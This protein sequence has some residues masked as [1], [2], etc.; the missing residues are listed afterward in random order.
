MPRTKKKSNRYWTSITEYAVAAYNRVESPVTREK[1]YLR[2]LYPALMKMSENLIN[3]LKPEYIDSSFEDL[4]TDLVTFLTERLAKFNPTAGK[5]YSYYTRTGFNY[6]IA[7]NQKAYS[8]LKNQYEEI[9][10]DEQRNVMIEIHNS[11]MRE[12]LQHFMDAYIQYCYDNLNTIFTTQ[13]D[14]H[15]ADSILHLFETRENLEQFNKKALY[16]LIR[17]RTGL[18]T[19]NITRVIKTLKDIYQTKFLEYEKLDYIKL[20]F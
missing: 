3:T 20:P 5:A 17:E 12:T 10:I 4:Q 13:S 19:N 7:E 16:I 6:L 1:I 11:E 9:N 18:E 15:V 8:K 2:F 14:I